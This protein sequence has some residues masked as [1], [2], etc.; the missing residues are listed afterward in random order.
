MKQKQESISKVILAFKLS[1]IKIMLSKAR[2]FFFSVILTMSFSHSAIANINGAFAKCDVSGSTTIY[3]LKRDIWFSNDTQDSKKRTLPASTFKI[4]HSLIALET[5]ST[6][7][8][9]IFKWDGITRTIPKWNQDTNLENAFKNSTVWVYEELATRIDIATYQHYLK[10]AEYFGNGDITHGK[11]DNF[12]VYGNWGISPEEQIHMLIKLYQNQLPFSLTTMQ[13]VKQ[14][15]HNSDT[16]S[17]T[18]FTEKDGINIGWWIGYRET[19]D[20]TL[21]FATRI[22]K[23][24]SKPIDK[25]VECRIT[26]TENILREFQNLTQ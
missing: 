1:E 25:F 3:D 14:F 16:Y 13:T 10:Q 11:N 7:Q 8:E 15:M 6:N 19:K 2:Q 21:F 4:F 12:W 24:T 26:I 5:G 23:P 9:E 17:K 20:G 18:G 22:E